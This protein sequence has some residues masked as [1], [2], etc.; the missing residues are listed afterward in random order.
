MAPG[1]SLGGEGGGAGAPQ[2]KVLAPETESVK[3]FPTPWVGG[4]VQR[5]A[6]SSSSK[7]GTDQAKAFGEIFIY[8]TFAKGF[9][10]NVL[11]FFLT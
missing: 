1:Q 8:K 11:F 4:G 5:I 3:K 2:V 7:G 9:F 6:D 10:S